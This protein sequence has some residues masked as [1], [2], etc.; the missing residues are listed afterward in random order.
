MRY[1]IIIS[2]L[3]LNSVTSAQDV[4]N[5]EGTNFGKYVEQYS[6]G[7]DQYAP[8]MVEYLAHLVDNRYASVLD[9]GCGTGIATRQLK[10][11]FPRVKGLDIDKAML[12]EAKRIE[13]MNTGTGRSIKYFQADVAKK[14]PFKDKQFDLI[15]ICEA[16]HWLVKNE[17]TKKAALAELYRVLKPGGILAIVH[18]GFEL[19]KDPF[20]VAKKSV[21]DDVHKKYTKVQ[22]LHPK[23]GN[24]AYN[25][26][27]VLQE[28]NFQTPQGEKI[29][30]HKVMTDIEK[31][32]ARVQ[33]ASKWNEIDSKDQPAALQEYRE[34]MVEIFKQFGSEQITK[35][36]YNKMYI[37]KRPVQE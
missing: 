27:N 9:V 24:S 23:S 7:R 1:L 35:N 25:P 28:F 37:G 5:I 8:E 13:K 2:M 31:E 12:K 10:P 36:A 33:S 6:K 19:E 11:Y 14:L 26:L 32:I 15:T 29:F 17:E 4:K 21:S 20:S 16:F 34:R 3:V 22:A 18:S 30:S